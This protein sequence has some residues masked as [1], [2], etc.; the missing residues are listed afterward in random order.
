MTHRKPTRPPQWLWL[1]DNFCGN[2]L[3][4]KPIETHLFWLIIWSFRCRSCWISMFHPSS[5]WKNC[6]HKIEF[7]GKTKRSSSVVVNQITRNQ[8]VKSRWSFSCTSPTIVRRGKIVSHKV[9][10]FLRYPDHCFTRVRL[11]LVTWQTLPRGWDFFF[12][13]L[14]W[15]VP[16]LVRLVTNRRSHYHLY[17]DVPLHLRQAYSKLWTT[18]FCTIVQNPILF[19]RFPFD[20]AV[21][22]CVKS[23]RKMQQKK[24]NRNW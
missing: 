13:P 4:I 21:Q 5:E 12:V 6:V 3:Q 15:I 10:S 19:Y 7:V 20:P 14:S 9:C 24:E 22:E 2:N 11:A 17:L 18:R 8:K 23:F 16:L 1:S